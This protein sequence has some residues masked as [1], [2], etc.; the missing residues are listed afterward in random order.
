MIGGFYRPDAGSIRL[1]GRNLAGAPA[2][3]VARAGIARTY[4]TTQLFGSL[5]VLDN[6]LTGLGGGRLVASLWPVP[7]PPTTARRAEGLL[8]FVGY[9]GP[10][11]TPAQDLPHVDRRL[12]EIARALATRPK[13]L[14]LDE[15]AAGLMRADKAALGSVLR[16]LAGDG[17]RR[18]PGRARHDPGHGRLGPCGRAGC[19][20]ARLRPGRRRRSAATPRSNRPTSAAARCRCARGLVPLP[21]SLPLQLDAVELRSRLRSRAGAATASPSRCARA[22]SWRCSGA[23]GAG[24]STIMRSLSGLLRPVSG[25]IRLRRRRGS[26]GSSRTASRRPDWC[27]CPRAGR[28]SPSS[29]CATTSCSAPTRARRKRWTT[30]SRPARSFPA[31]CANACIR[32][33]ACSRAVS[34]RCWRSPAA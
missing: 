3:K 27:S 2:W 8:A 29:A 33:R 5:S 17:H 12:V 20:P 10:L 26:S 31:D 16:N 21:A 24:K 28:C 22:S 32:E 25:T 6:V 13:V 4:Q 19:R 15:P 34:S 1:G 14:L 9:R 7:R 11:D 18:H 23:N 30:T